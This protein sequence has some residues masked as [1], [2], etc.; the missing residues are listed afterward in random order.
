[1]TSTQIVEHLARE[2]A[3]D[4]QRIR[5]TLEMIDAG[6]AAPFVGRVRRSET[7]GLSEG[8]IRRLDRGRTELEELDRRRGTVLRM[9]GAE[10]PETSAG[11]E[12]HVLSAPP[13]V[14]ERVRTCMERFELEDLF[15]PHRRPEPEVQLALDRGLGRLADLLVAP[16]P[17]ERRAP[18]AE[19]AEHPEAPEGED[20]AET[21]QPVAAAA[22]EEG[23]ATEE[24]PAHD[25]GPPEQAGAEP[26]SGGEAEEAR[27]GHEEAQGD[28]AHRQPA[29]EQ[30][31]AGESAFVEQAGAD[32][33][34]EEEGRAALD[35][36]RRVAEA[37]ALDEQALLHGQ[38]E[39]TPALARVCAPFVNP[40]RGVHTE[41]EALSGA[42]RILSDR[43]GRDTRLRGTL[44]RMLRKQGVLTVRPL[45]DDS[46]LG[47]LRGMLKLRQPL[48]Q[49]QGHRLLAIRQAQKQRAVQAAIT[50]NRA[51]AL[52]KVRSTLGRHTDPDFASVLD[53]IALRT[54]EYR[55]LPLLEADIR[56]ELKERGD[57]EALRFL[58][59]HLRQVLLTPGVGTVPVAGVDVNAKGDWTLGLLDEHGAVQGEPVRVETGDKDAAALGAEL[60]IALWVENGAGRTPRVRA[61]ALGHGKVPRAALLRLRAALAAAGLPLTVVIVNESGLS[62]YASSELARRELAGL[63]VPQRQ[64]VSLGRRLQDPLAELVKVDPRHLGLGPEQGLVSKANLRRALEETVESCVALVGLDV[65]R[66]SAALLARVPGLDEACARAIVER[67]ERSPFESREELRGEGLLDEA[68]WTNAVAF[69]RVRGSNPLDATG[70]HPE[71]YELAR[72]LVE[73]TG[74]SVEESLGRAGVTKGLRRVD[75]G[76][77]EHGWRDLMRELSWPGRDPRPRLFQP[78]LLDPGTDRAALTR[79]CV[80]EGVISNVTSFGAFVDLGLEH[81]GLIHV[82]EIS[83]RYVRDARELVSIGETVRARVLDG[84]SPRL[85]LSLKRVPPPQR[86]ERKQGGR[87][88]AVAPR[89][90]RAGGGRGGRERAEAPRAGVRAAQSRRDGRVTGGRRGQRAGEGGARRGSGRPDRGERDEGFRPEDL[91]AAAGPKVTYNPFARFF[92]GVREGEGEGG[93]AAQAPPDRTSGE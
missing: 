2:F 80:V 19:A 61:L 92:K 64:A 84:S 17:P 6:L 46:K 36:E 83:D 38:I 37:A 55:L 13:E 27:Q 4:V 69:L 63:Q 31:A 10:P 51:A 90:G 42:M 12:L 33:D 30:T 24:H 81:D 89:A 56:L 70:L 32:G 72:R 54:L 1:M 44:R 16:L 88:E 34:E 29:T 14:I 58:S 67:R 71:Q 25:A 43:L 15:L 7:G 91:R 79:D 53:A 23:H 59:Q 18:G 35:G 9:L 78:Q 93:T 66:A 74:G 77:E 65:N 3:T 8:Q 28:H 11:P 60:S 22:A 57:E 82:S 5:D 41:I 85:A 49:V 68:Q 50:L 47:R 62:S 20:E 45:V 86:E 40:D 75:F 26:E 39:L 21:W 73:A 76:V 48:R 52:P 87:R